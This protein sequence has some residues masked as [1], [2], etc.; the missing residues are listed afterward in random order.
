[1]LGTFKKGA[2]PMEKTTHDTQAWIAQCWISFILAIGAT[3]VG[4]W[5]MPVDAWVRG[6]MGLG[7][8]YSVGSSFT[9]AKTLRDQHESRRV[10]SVVQNAKVEEI[11]SKRPLAS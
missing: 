11:L 4:L 1:M 6:F 3:A 9:L 10:S 2:F 5:N 7:L 8:L